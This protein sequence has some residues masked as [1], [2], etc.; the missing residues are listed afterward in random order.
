[1]VVVLLSCLRQLQVYVRVICDFTNVMC[2]MQIF[3]CINNNVV[4]LQIYTSDS[5]KSICVRPVKVLSAVAAVVVV[6]GF[7]FLTWQYKS[8]KTKRVKQ[9]RFMYIN[10][11]EMNKIVAMWQCVKIATNEFCKKEIASTQCQLKWLGTKK[12]K[13]E[14]QKKKN[15]VKN[16]TYCFVIGRILVVSYDCK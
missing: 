10:S 1:M 13:Q 12:K 3:E 7:F 9:K 4:L 11:N 16:E 8:H 2:V 14:N 15:A 6:L 5:T